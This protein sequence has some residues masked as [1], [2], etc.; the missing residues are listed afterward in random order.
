M[1]QRHRR[2]RG[3]V[4]HQWH[5]VIDVLPT[6][7]D[8]VGVPEPETFAGVEQQPIEGISLHYTFADADAP[9]RHTTQY[10]EMVGNRG[11]YHQ[12]WT[13]VTRH[14]IP[15]E[16]VDVTDRPFEDDVWELYDHATDWTQAHDLAAEHP[17]QL[18]EL[19]AI[20]ELGGREVPRP[21]ARR[22]VSPSARTR[23]SPGVWTSTR[24]ARR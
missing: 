12:G 20:F 13:A 3:E 11:I 23:T 14:G 7:L 1:G 15:W 21:P 4:R 19:Q 16:M 6:I 24:A 9:D 10:F 2:P 22:R 8:A 18:Q 5:H 17:E